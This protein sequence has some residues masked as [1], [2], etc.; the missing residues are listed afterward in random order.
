MNISV[1][2]TS[3]KVVNGECKDN[4]PSGETYV[5]GAFP[6][7]AGSDGDKCCVEKTAGKNPLNVLVNTILN[8]SLIY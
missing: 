3:D 8:M 5:K 6:K 7:C 4:C 1:G 2:C